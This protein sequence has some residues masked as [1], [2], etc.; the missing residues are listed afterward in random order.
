MRFF[1]KIVKAFKQDDEKAHGIVQGGWGVRLL[2][3]H[4]FNSKEN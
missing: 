2:N 4:H 1:K 3:F